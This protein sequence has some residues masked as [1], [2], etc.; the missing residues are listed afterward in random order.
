MRI[1]LA[2]GRERVTVETRDLCGFYHGRGLDWYGES[3]VREVVF[4]VG[5]QNV[6][7]MHTI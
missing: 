4:G 2:R 3:Y 5:G 6:L 7:G 1:S